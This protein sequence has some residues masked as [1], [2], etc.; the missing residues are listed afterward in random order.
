MSDLLHGEFLDMSTA[1]FIEAYT[2]GPWPNIY[3]KMRKEGY[4]LITLDEAEWYDGR[5][6]SNNP[7]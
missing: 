5:P 2:F 7:L 3:K 4:K 6:S 1:I